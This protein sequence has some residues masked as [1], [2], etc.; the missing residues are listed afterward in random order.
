MVMVPSWAPL[1][2]VL[3][4]EGVAKGQHGRV[5]LGLVKVEVG[6]R[7]SDRLVPDELTGW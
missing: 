3:D 7:L 5:D 6:L 1:V 2:V 4:D